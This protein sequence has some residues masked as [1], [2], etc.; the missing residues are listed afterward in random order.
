MLTHAATEQV[1]PTMIER[2]GSTI[3]YTTGGASK[4]LLAEPVTPMVVA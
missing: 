1:L 2:D 3:L 4:N